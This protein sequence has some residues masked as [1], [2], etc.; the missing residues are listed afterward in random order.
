MKQTY[1]GGFTAEELLDGG[2]ILKCL[3]GD[4]P[5]PFFCRTVYKD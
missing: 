1:M 4:D 3:R 2:K 5:I